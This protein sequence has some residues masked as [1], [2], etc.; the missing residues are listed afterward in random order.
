NPSRESHPSIPPSR[1]YRELCREITN[2][3]LR[4]RCV[5]IDINHQYWIASFANAHGGS[6]NLRLLH[7]RGSDLVL[8]S[9]HRLDSDVRL[10]DNIPRRIAESGNCTANESSRREKLRQMSYRARIRK[11]QGNQI[12]LTCHLTRTFQIANVKTSRLL[13]SEERRVGKKC[14]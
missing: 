7:Q 5:A 14:T 1:V 13:R 9:Y 10:I 11:L 8:S 6:Q 12:S 4:I 2:G 3:L